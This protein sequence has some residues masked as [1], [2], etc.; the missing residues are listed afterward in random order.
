[1]KTRDR[2]KEYKVILD[3]PDK[4]FTCLA[5]LKLTRKGGDG[6][7]CNEVLPQHRS[8]EIEV[9]IYK[10]FAEPQQHNLIHRLA[11]WLICRKNHPINF[12]NGTH[13]IVE[14][15]SYVVEILKHRFYSQAKYEADGEMAEPKVKGNHVRPSVYV[16]PP[17]NTAKGTLIARSR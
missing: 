7:P 14:A 16:T 1:M 10:I 5:P 4:H 13:Y 11:Q 9:M 17:N 2:L 8:E 6:G 15:N 3:L 12:D